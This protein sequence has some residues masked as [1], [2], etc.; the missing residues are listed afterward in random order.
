[1]NNLAAYLREAGFVDGDM[2]QD[3]GDLSLA[4]YCT[5]LTLER[6][7]QHFY[8]LVVTYDGKVVEVVGEVYLAKKNTYK[9]KGGLTTD[10]MRAKGFMPVRWG[11]LR[12]LEEV[13]NFL[14][15]Q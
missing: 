4:K 6:N 11:L 7:G 10:Q 13:K 2:K 15:F 3:M 9:P 1:M 12:T 8:M 5:Y 14:D